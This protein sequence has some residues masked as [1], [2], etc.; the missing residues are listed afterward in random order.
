[1]PIIKIKLM[2]WWY[3]DGHQKSGSDKSDSDSL[4]SLYD[5]L[6]IKDLEADDP[7]IKQV[8]KI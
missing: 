4:L 1:M 3:G 2:K 6:N 5:D 8:L 7:T